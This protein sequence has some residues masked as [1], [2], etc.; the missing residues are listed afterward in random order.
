[1]R[2]C[3][4]RE[5]IQSNSGSKVELLIKESF[6]VTDEEL[7]FLKNF[8]N[9]SE[10]KEALKQFLRSKKASV[11]FNLS[12]TTLYGQ[13]ATAL[14]DFISQQTETDSD[15]LNNGTLDIEQVEESTPTN[16]DSDDQYHSGDENMA[17]DKNMNNQLAKLL[18]GMPQFQRES[19]KMEDFLDQ[20]ETYIDL[21]F[22]EEHQCTDESYRKL[23]KY[24]LGK[25]PVAREILANLVDTDDANKKKFSYLKEQLILLIDGKAKKSFAAVSKELFT[26]KMTDFSSLLAYYHRYLELKVLGKN[27]VTDELMVESFTTGLPKSMQIAVRTRQPGTLQEAYT[28]AVELYDRPNAYAQNNLRL[29]Q[30]QNNNSEINRANF[31]RGNPRRGNFRGNRGNQRGFSRNSNR[32]SSEN[33]RNQNQNNGNS[34][35]MRRGCYLCTGNHLIAD[36]PNLAKAQRH[37]RVNQVQLD[38]SQQQQ[39]VEGN[40]EIED[41]FGNLEL[42]DNVWDNEKIEKFSHFNESFGERLIKV[43]PDARSSAGTVVAN[44]GSIL[45]SERGSEVSFENSVKIYKVNF[46][47]L[48]KKQVFLMDKSCKIIYILSGVVDSG[49]Q[50][51]TISYNLVK[52]LKLPLIEDN[53]IKVTAWDGEVSYKVRGYTKLKISVPGVIGPVFIEPIVVDENDCNL[54]GLDFLAQTGGKFEMKPDG[55]LDIKFDCA[56]KVK[57]AQHVV[58]KPGQIKNVKVKKSSIKNDGLLIF[59]TSKNSCAEVL[60]GIGDTNTENIVIVNPSLT[61][62]LEI[63]IGTVVADA[64]LGCDRP[65]ED[66]MKKFTDAEFSKLVEEKLQHLEPKYRSKMRKILFRFRGNF[67]KGSGKKVGSVDEPVDLNPSNRDIKIPLE[68]RRSFNQNIWDIIN[69]KL[70]EL[71]NLDLIEDCKNPIYCPANLVLARRRGSTKTRLCVDYRRANSVIDDNFFPYRL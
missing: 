37:I 32:Y 57:A 30:D 71:K 14:I 29:Q 19:T 49:A 52:K 59:E 10:D 36:C 44:Q 39:Q 13:V 40:G 56:L 51:S 6:Q 21:S 12:Y 55:Q 46:Q 69:P 67:D 64:Y 8:E 23:L 60:N 42:T 16:S 45:K 20:F 35:R 11:Q 34:Q 9:D 33:T 58:I 28:I 63:K 53:S 22:F 68:K 38:D 25:D 1:M 54:F 48:I 70:E 17:T 2:G 62:T 66:E 5:Y 26:I 18:K 41:T 43:P 50:K 27:A 15:L 61:N 47:K 31:S 24:S 3:E 4:R 7:Q 65:L